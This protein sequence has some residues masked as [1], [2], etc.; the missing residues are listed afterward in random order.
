MAPRKS[1]PPEFLPFQHPKLVETPPRGAGWRH[2][3]KL[4]GYRIQ[5]RVAAG[6]VG[7]RTREA[8]DW[9]DRFPDL[10]ALARALP[11]AILDGELCVL[12]P[13]DRPDFSALRSAV[14]RRQGGHI[15]GDLVV[16]LFDLLWEGRQDLRALPLAERLA[17]LEALA[18]PVVGERFRLAQALP[19]AGPALL[20]AAC[21]LELEGIVSKRL[22]APY[23]GGPARRETWV[24]SKCRPSGEVVI[25]GWRTEGGRFR[26]LLAGVFED[27]R[28][29][30]VGRVHTGYSA[31]KL[32]ELMPRLE[33][34]ETHASPFPPTETP[35]LRG[36]HWVRPELVAR[37]SYA[38]VTRAGKLRQ[39]AYHGLREDKAP[40][41]VRTERPTAPPPAEPR[42][43]P[44]AARPA[45]ENPR[46]IL[47]PAAAGRPAV[48]KADLAGY[49][50]GVSRWLLPY[51]RGRPCTVVI[52]P[53]GVEGQT[54]WVRHEGHW[55]GALRTSPLITHWAVAEKGKTYPGFDTV[56]AL[57][58]AAD[59]AV[60][61]IHPW[62]SAPG[63]PMTPGRL[64]F[65]LD[66]EEGQ[67]MAAV[68]AA[69]F[70][71]KE[72]LEGLG[73][74]AFLKAS[75]RRG[76]HLVTPLDTRGD[77]P[78]WPAAR[79]FAKRLCEEMAA[80][81]PD[82]YSTAL[83]KD[84]RRGRLFLDYL[85]N[86]PGHH[87]VG[88][89]SPRT[90]PAATVSMPLSWAEARRGLPEPATVWTA[91]ERLRRRN[92]WSGYDRA[93]APLPAAP[94]RA[95]RSLRRA[96]ATETSPDRG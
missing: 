34:L 47:W 55:R 62:N 43:A 11:D 12:G 38:E 63:Q 87:A 71:L 5:L 75:G 60:V 69:A 52:A 77:G 92:P 76:L 58:Q 22:D 44:A 80:D 78:S 68:L 19:G 84:K 2:E 27:G 65:D 89:L 59:I 25:G 15:E 13:D 74:A 16:F 93:A 14:G 1:S 51:I 9:S 39:S 28:L 88:L 54:T 23:Q 95:G 79:T 81:S 57:V 18:A 29:R 46:K 91:A 66:P 30:Y 7:W 61:E 32:A 56:E 94:I 49:Y 31:A 67:D 21:R 41:H 17:R 8:H 36:V 85:R 72:R 70:E 42:D 45:V 50:E 37:V 96:A 35:R 33:A 4:D 10:S 53:D 48:S 20:D 83:P 82:L 3:V 90:S 64:V 26:S 40:S 73:L 86:D 6:R 24:K